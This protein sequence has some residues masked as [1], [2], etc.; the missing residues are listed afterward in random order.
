MA[1]HT[2]NEDTRGKLL[3][4][5]TATLTTIMFKRGFR[6]CF[7]GDIHPLNPEHARMAGPA[8]TLR[9]IPSREDLDHIKV[10]EDRS[11][12][13]R[14]G[15]EECPPGHVMVIDSRKDRKAASAG[16]ILVARLWK[17][18]VAGIVTDG[19]F[20][21]SADI[22][23]LPFPAFHAGPS[24]P[25]NLIRHH[26]VDLNVPI[27]CGDV[28]VYPGDMVVSDMDGVV[29]LPRD[30]ADSVAEEAVEQTLFETY[31]QERVMEGETIFGLYPPSPETRARFDAWR[32]QTRAAGGSV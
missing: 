11:H 15:V 23:R 31:V 3:T 7:I 9:Y 20:R 18:G 30:I 6:N 13:Q 19:G 21:D 17:R 5:S 32:R 24:A 16:D 12:P 10:F 2:L 8:Y 29:V 28:A 26:A 22:A 4:V 25:T 1:E 27:G 14:K